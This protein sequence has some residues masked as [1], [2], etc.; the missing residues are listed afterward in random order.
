[1]NS[2]LPAWVWELDWDQ[3]YKHPALYLP[4]PTAG[5]PED[6]RRGG[7]RSLAVLGYELCG[8]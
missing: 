6:P 3:P 2:A 5:H 4:Q 8:L 1:M 7:V